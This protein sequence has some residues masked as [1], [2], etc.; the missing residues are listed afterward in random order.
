MP[1]K[2]FDLP[3]PHVYADGSVTSIRVVAYE[4]PD[5]SPSIVD[6]RDSLIVTGNPDHARQIA[7][8]LLIAA[9]LCE[10]AAIP[11]PL[12][13]ARGITAAV[14]RVEHKFSLVWISEHPG[15]AVPKLSKAF[16]VPIASV[17]VIWR[18]KR[19]GAGDIILRREDYS[20]ACRIA[21]IDDPKAAAETLLAYLG[22]PNGI[23]ID[24]SRKGFLTVIGEPVDV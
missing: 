10:K 17:S 8:A 11:A 12:G 5:T 9:D 16:G 7:R 15:H 20:A 21:A 1:E 6:E 13:T 4:V 2:L 22:S 19:N 14:S 24:L 23:S 3:V 18:D